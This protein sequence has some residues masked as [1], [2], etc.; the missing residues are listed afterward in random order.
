MET[1]GTDSSTSRLTAPGRLAGHRERQHLL[2]AAR[3]EHRVQQPALQPGEVQQVVDQPLELVGGVVHRAD[4]LGPV[5]LAAGAGQQSVE[6]GAHR[7]QRRTQVVRDRAQQGG[8][9]G[10]GALQHAG[11]LLAFPQPAV[12]Q[13]QPGLHREGLEHPLVGGPQRSTA[14]GEHVVLVDGDPGVSLVGRRGAGGAGRGQHRPPGRRR[15]SA[16]RR[17]PAPKVSRSRATIASAVSCPVSTER[18]SAPMV[19]ASALARV[20]SPARREARSTTVATAAAT[21]TKTSRTTTLRGSAT[22]NVRTG[23][24]KK[25]LRVTK[26]TTAASSAGS[27]P[28]TRATT[29][30]EASSVSMAR[31]SW[32]VSWNSCS[33]ATSTSGSSTAP[34]HPVTWRDRESGDSSGRDSARRATWS[35]VTRCTSIAPASDAIRSP[36]VPVKSRRSRE[37][38]ETPT[39]IIV[40]LAPAA[41]STTAAETS[42]P[43]TEWKVPPS[44]ATSCWAREMRRSSVV[45]QA[46]GGDDVHGQQLRPRRA[47]GQPGAPPDQRLALGAAGDGDD[48]PLLGGPALLDAVRPPVVVELVVDA[49]GQPQQRQLAQGGEVADPEVRREG[50]VD[51]LGLV[52]VAVRHPAAQ[53]VRA[54]CRRA[55][56]SR[57]CAPPRRA[58][59]RAAGP[60]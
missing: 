51:V 18:E 25:K 19:A 37:C 52:D 30:V 3:A 38:R 59:S 20:A 58:P 39:T 21:A 16:V 35:W 42:S 54:P 2:E 34:T 49:V 8:R 41:K 48:D 14:Q 9:S 15:A 47:L 11:P 6:G 32:S 5:G 28:P 23:G 36:V 29:T 10:L 33:T 17:R 1:I 43:T 45:L 26:P 27:S 56:W 22:V 4:Q 44:E 60:R 31:G 13:H 12:L 40:A 55:G 57:R 50:G 24:V 46:V 7:G 53:G